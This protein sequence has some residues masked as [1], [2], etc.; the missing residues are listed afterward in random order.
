MNKIIIESHNDKYFLQRL[1]DELGLGNIEID[2]PL[3]NI[4]EFICLDGIGN[5][6]NKL[7]DLKLDEIDKLGIVLDANSIGVD[8]RLKQVNKIF[9]KLNLNIIFSNINKMEYDA[10]NT[11]YI[12]CHIL[13]IDGYG[14]L[15]NI[16]KT[17]KKS[18]SYFADCLDCWK[19]CLEDNS[20]SI[21]EKDF[22]KFWI[23][24][25]IRFDTCCEKE[26]QRASKYCNFEQ[27]MKKDIW[28]MNHN[29]LKELKAFLKLFSKDSD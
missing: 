11:I 19:Q 17:I 15:E 13:N 18:D 3:C 8:E 10:S 22:I 6:K 12:A 28:D 4:E 25:Y 9:E 29:T 5:L 20:K 2:E 24:N 27:A 26:K 7:M 16:L 14:E 1:L 23:N 21:S